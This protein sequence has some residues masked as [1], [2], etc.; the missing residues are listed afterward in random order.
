MVFVRYFDKNKNRI[1]EHFL[2]CKPLTSS[3]KGTD[4]YQL[5]D[6]FFTK[7]NINWKTKIGHVCCDRAQSMLGET[8]G[9]VGLAKKESPHCYLHRYALAFKNLPRNLKFVLDSAVQAVNFIK[10][11]ALNYRLFTVLCTE[12]EV[13]Q[14]ALLYHTNIR[15]LFR[16]RITWSRLNQIQSGFEIYSL[17]IRSRWRVMTSS[18]NN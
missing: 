13:R 10:S 3:R 16:G 4:V 7:K 9:F 8:S 5:V 18:K 11:R 15:W 1:T 17:L 6:G 12:M 2:F 14:N